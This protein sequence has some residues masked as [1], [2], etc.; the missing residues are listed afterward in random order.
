MKKALK[1]TGITLLILIALAFI[2][3]VVFKKQIQALVKKEINKSLNAKVDFTNVK[4]S[5]FKHFPKVGIVIENLSIVGQGEFASDTLLAAKK[6]DASAGLFS[7]LKGKDIK[8]SGVTIESPRIHALVTKDG[9]AN[10]DIAKQKGDTSNNADTS[11]SA[12][13][14]T[15]NHYT[16]NNGYLLL[17]DESAN[18]YLELDDFDHTGKGDLTADVFTLSTTTR[19]T[20]ASFTQDD[21]PYLFNT[22]TAIDADV[23]IDNNTNTYSF[24][25]DDIKLN[26]LQ[27][28]ADGFVKMI[29]GSTFDMN[30]NFKSPSNDFGDILSMVP[31]IYKKD[32]STIKTSGKA[33]FNG[34][35]KGTS[36]ATQIPA[37]SVNLEV[38]DGFFQYPD[39]PKPV[40]NIQLSLK[41]SNADGSPDNAVID[42]SNGHLEMDNEPFDFRFVYKNPVTVQLID[43]A[44]KGKLDLSQ[45]SQFIKLDK[46]T[47][48][49]GNVWADAFVKGPLKAIQTQTGNFTAGGFFDIKNLYYSDNSFPQ[50]IQNGSMKATLENSGGI[51]DKTA[52][53]IS[54]GHIEIGKDPLDF[55]LQL[56]NPFSSIDFSGHAKGRFTLDNIKQFTTLEAG[57]AI[58]GILNADIGFAGNKTAITKKQYD[59]INLSGT[60]NVNNL[61]YVSKA[62]PTGITINNTQL[63]F[64]PKNATLSNLTG[65]YLGTNFSGTG[66]LDNLV[67][68]AMNEQSLTGN[69]NITA[70]KIN[71]N[72]WMG[73]TPM[74][75]PSVTPTAKT[76]TSSASPFLVPA[77]ISVTVNA[78]AGKV[79]YDKVDYNNINGV[80]V[81]NDEMVKLQN[82]STQAL[83]GSALLNGSYSTKVHKKEPDIGLSYDI[84]DM[85]V[86]KVFNSFVTAKALMPIGKFLSGK[87]SSQLSLTGNLYGDMMPKLNS[88]SGKGNLLLLEGVLKKFAPLEKIATLLSIDKLKSISVKDIKNYIEFSNGKVLVK[89][90]TIK[91][92]NIEMV[93]SGFHSFDQSIDYAI[94]MKLPRSVMGSQGNNFVNNLVTQANSKGIPIK[95]SETINLSIKMTGSI[96]NPTLG[97]DLKEVA[98][99]AIKDI[100]EQAKDFVQAKLDSAKQKAKDSLSVIKDQLE[101][102]L[103][104]KLKE[105]IFGKDTTSQS[106]PQDST[107]KKNQP[108]IKKTIKDIFIKPK[109]TPKDSL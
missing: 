76:T 67:G 104:D 101:E 86:Q 13:K 2:I 78:K 52:I 46:G 57:S 84:K 20:A 75:A 17:R 16:I 18:T 63:S 9:H 61:K 19:A 25:T 21:I 65:N 92:D 44:A 68:Y 47:K 37:Y 41:A 102:K 81:I 98:G 94:Q 28:N 3:P 50:P 72:D 43:A 23:K 97:V 48:L 58:S 31:A 10:W 53:N 100:E 32:F 39:L 107:P 108:S 96:D 55:S 22:K 40:K 14:L 56:K 103:K 87:L 95:L 79:E 70:D 29:N 80:L 42:I 64:N 77:N 105:Q 109:K 4:L 51:A 54:T 106:T 7:V 73:T 71:L 99:D 82:I 27:L 85:D 83:D 89:P 34:F 69:L 88:L 74:P 5:L 90:F 35:I 49:A 1:I 33:V 38:K 15:L 11:A 59:K 60:A 26:N 12:F 8:V 30:I 93:I 62:Y 36:S 6:I 24:K 66:V 91:I 45:V